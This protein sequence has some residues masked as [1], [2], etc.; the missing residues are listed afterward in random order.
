[1][2][3]S[4]GAWIGGGITV[5]TGLVPDLSV[6]DIDP[7]FE[8]CRIDMVT[9]PGGVVR[10]ANRSAMI[11]ANGKFCRGPLVDVVFTDS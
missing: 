9:N 1:M 11:P 8:D 10:S 4:R 2:A 3:A 6:M 5:A 7:K